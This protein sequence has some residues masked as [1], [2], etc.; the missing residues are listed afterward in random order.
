MAAAMGTLPA[1]SPLPPYHPS[2]SL[3]LLHPRLPSLSLQAVPFPCNHYEPAGTSAHA[4]YSSAALPPW[5]GHPS[6]GRGRG[7]E[8]CE[9]SALVR[10]WALFDKSE[11][12]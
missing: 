7:T 10:E 12:I 6:A 8:A 2:L 9:W 4:P 5:Q 1:A 11:R 3:S